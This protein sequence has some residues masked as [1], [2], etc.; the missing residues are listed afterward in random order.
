MALMALKLVCAYAY[1]ASGE[2]PALRHEIG[3]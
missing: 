2:Y 1:D 3:R